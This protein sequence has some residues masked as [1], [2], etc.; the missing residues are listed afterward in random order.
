MSAAQ[1]SEGKGTEGKRERDRGTSAQKPNA[2]HR[3][4]TDHHRLTILPPRRDCSLSI[5]ALVARRLVLLTLARWLVSSAAPNGTREMTQLLAESRGRRLRALGPS[6]DS[7]S[8]LAHRN[9]QAT[10][11]PRRHMKELFAPLARPNGSRGIELDR[12]D[13]SSD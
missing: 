6:S 2:S 9:T 7:S 10:T 11:Q 13:A 8:R 3:I 12:D 1:R 4:K 5:E